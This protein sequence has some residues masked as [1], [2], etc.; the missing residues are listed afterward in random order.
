M[1]AT[2]LGLLI[3]I[4]FFFAYLYMASRQIRIYLAARGIVVDGWHW[5]GAAVERAMLELFEKY[6]SE[7]GLL[8][9]AVLQQ[10]IESTRD[11]IVAQFKPGPGHW[12]A[13]AIF[14]GILIAII[15]PVYTQLIQLWV[16]TKLEIWQLTLLVSGICLSTALLTVATVPMAFVGSRTRL[17]IYNQSL[18]AIRINL[19]KRFGVLRQRK[20]REIE[21]ETEMARVS[22]ASPSLRRRARLRRV[23]RR[24]I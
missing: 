17:E 20:D 23:T 18:C 14:F 16:T 4:P 6:L 24:F 19:L 13:L 11:E 2:Y 8:N 22:P 1:S 15:Q 21:V 7:R 3:T 9:E 5:R 10:F 12:A